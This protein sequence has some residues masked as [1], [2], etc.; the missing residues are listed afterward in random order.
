L[1]SDRP[2]VLLNEAF[3]DAARHAATQRYFVLDAGSGEVTRYAQTLQAYTQAEY[4]DLLAECGY[5]GVR[6]YP[7]L[8]GGDADRQPGLFAL[9]ATKA[10]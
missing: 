5:A 8:S 9:T 6:F 7:S 2:H 1:F 10:L 3:W 4:G